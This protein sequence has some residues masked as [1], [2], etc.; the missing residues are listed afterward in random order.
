[1][2]GW[3]RRGQGL[4]NF[5]HNAG[6]VQRMKHNARITTVKDFFPFVSGFPTP[7]MTL[8]QRASQTFSSICKSWNEDKE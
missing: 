3:E 7:Q 8:H 2:P 5:S 6:D 4:F 1:V